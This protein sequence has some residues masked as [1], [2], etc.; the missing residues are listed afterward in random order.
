MGFTRITLLKMAQ[1]MLLG[2]YNIEW[3]TF[4]S[5]LSDNNK[6]LYKSKLYADVTL[7]SDD[8]IKVRAHRTVLSGASDLFKKLLM[9]NNNAEPW[10]Y[11]KGVKLQELQAILEFIYTGGTKVYENRIELFLKTFKEFEIKG[12]K[13][14]TKE[15]ETFR[16]V[17][18]SHDSS[19]ESQKSFFESSM[20]IEDS[21]GEKPPNT[22]N[23]NTRDNA[24]SNVPRKK[25]ILQH[26][27]RS[28][29]A[30]TRSQTN[31][32]LK[33]SANRKLPNE[34]TAFK[35]HENKSKS[36]PKEITKKTE[37]NAEMKILQ[38]L[39]GIIKANEGSV[40]SHQCVKNLWK[41]LKN[42]DI[43]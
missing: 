36:N 14:Y 20:I 3:N 19:E 7:V 22:N 23:R 28:Q 18:E 13:I 5:N 11:V 33:N 43:Q 35:N 40:I 26:L 10:I 24:K 9:M 6:E 42:N 37:I 38:D 27:I 25:S 41:Y 34:K 2:K 4:Q 15:N 39:A 17:K 32:F 29:N 21:S 12:V 1:G 31:E 16:T 8:L 30:R